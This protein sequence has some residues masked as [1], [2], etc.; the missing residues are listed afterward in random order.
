MG[1]DGTAA[2][3]KVAEEAFG[4]CAEATNSPAAAAIRWD[5]GVSRASSLATF[6]GRASRAAG[7]TAALSAVA[8]ALSAGG[9]SPAPATLPDAPSPAVAAPSLAVAPPS[10]AVAPPSVTARPETSTSVTVYGNPKDVPKALIHAEAQREIKEEETQRIAVVVPNFNTVISGVGVPLDP[11][12]KVDLAWH[13]AA[14]PF[15]VVGAFVLGGV[16]EWSGSHRAFGWGPAGYAKRVGANLADVLDGTMLAG[17]VYPILLRQDP[18]YFRKATGPFGTRLRHALAAPYVCRG[19][20]GRRQPNASNILGNLSAGAISNLYYPD[21]GMKLTILS[22][23]IVTFEGALGTIALEFAPD[24]EAKLSRRRARRQA[25]S[26]R[27]QGSDPAAVAAAGGPP[28]GG[29]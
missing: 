12:Q 26:A 17:A 9:Q 5:M 28:S 29:D 18:R 24:V 21:T 6:A 3:R 27:R 22:T 7:R 2:R 25:E 13:T 19:D 8:A 14:D 20:N 4:I 16:S 11:L 10:P 23:A 1:G 15:N